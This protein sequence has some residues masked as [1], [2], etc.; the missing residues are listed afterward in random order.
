MSTKHGPKNQG[1]KGTAKKVVGKKVAVCGKTIAASATTVLEPVAADAPVEDAD[2]ATEAPAK[3][4]RDMTID[5]LRAEYARV[6]GRET[7]STDRRYLCWKLAEAAKGRIPIGPTTRRAARPAADMQVL[8][9][10]M[11]R[12]TVAKLDAAAKDMG[13]KSRSALIRAAIVALLRTGT[14]DVTNAAANAIES[15]IA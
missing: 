12:D 2:A 4:K 9:L 6:I 10:G 15:D 11:L 5:D 1:K 14:T 7:T 3:R 13:F 8:P